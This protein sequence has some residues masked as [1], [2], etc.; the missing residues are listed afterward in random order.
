MLKTRRL[1]GRECWGGGDGMER[2]AE[3][4]ETGERGI[5]D[6]PLPPISSCSALLSLPSP[7][8]QHSSLSY[9]RVF[10]A[11]LLPTFSPSALLS[12]LSLPPSRP[13]HLSPSHK[14]IRL[15]HSPPSH[16]FV[17]NTPFP[18]TSSS[19]ALLN[20]PHISSSALLSFL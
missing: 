11:T 19:S 7:R 15:Q 5:A 20:L 16:L 12:L 10:S 14:Y 6:T 9:L 17:F 8:L 4:E 3:D 13:Q 18:P 1:G 2:S